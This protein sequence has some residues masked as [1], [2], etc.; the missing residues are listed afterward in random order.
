LQVKEAEVKKYL[1]VDGANKNVN[2]K[3]DSNNFEERRFE[4][5]RMG[6]KSELTFVI[7]FKVS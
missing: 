6:E 3:R 2:F 7:K 1:I 4:N 5:V